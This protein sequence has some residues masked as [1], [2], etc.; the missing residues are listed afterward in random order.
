MLNVKPNCYGILQHLRKAIRCSKKKSF[1]MFDG[2]SDH[3]DLSSAYHWTGQLSA[4]L[5]V[6]NG[7]G[8]SVRKL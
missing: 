4:V 6:Q 1:L 8:L 3:Q 2:V 7:T 5:S